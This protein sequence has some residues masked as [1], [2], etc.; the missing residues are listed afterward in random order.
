MIGLWPVFTPPFHRFGVI[1]GTW[2]L[3]KQC[4]IV[5][6]IKNIL[7]ASITPRMAC[8]QRGLIQDSNREWIRLQGHITPGPVDWDGVAVGL[9]SGL[10]VWIE[11]DSHHL[12]AIELKWWQRA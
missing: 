5:Q 9:K 11:A 1:K 3:F 10:A 2:S 7:L 8:Q 6:W 12:T 4:Q